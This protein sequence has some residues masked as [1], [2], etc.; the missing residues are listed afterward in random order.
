[1]EDYEEPQ[2]E[3]KEHPKKHPKR[4]KR[5]LY[6]LLG[7]CIA[8]VVA[9][10]VGLAVNIYISKKGVAYY[11]DLAST[12]ERRPPPV[13]IA[14]PPQPAPTDNGEQSAESP[15]ELPA[16]VEP[17]PPED[18][19]IPYVD[20]EALGEKYPGIVGWIKLDGTM[21][22]YPIMQTTNNYFYLSYL[23]DGTKGRPGS[24]FLDNRSSPD[25]SDRNSA[26]YGHYS[27]IGEMFGSLRFYRDQAYYEAHPIINIY[28]SEHDY[29]LVLVAG[30][31]VD[32]GIETPPLKFK[33][34]AAF[35]SFIANI[36]NRSFFKSGIDVSP[37]DKLLSLCTC[38]YDF[39]N[40]RLVLVGKLVET[41]EKNN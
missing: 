30:Y 13:S 31:L 34:D 4:K 35:E 32:S 3:T 36:K 29:D 26:I 23:P 38:A 24:I 37:D 12:V 16:A 14:T 9:C 27:S 10:I 1:M 25:L 39:T 19:W 15:P 33:D 40:A 8:A 11:S 22:D 2:E 7:V 18:I 41:D 5:I 21:I 17:A 28:T 6:T 20:F